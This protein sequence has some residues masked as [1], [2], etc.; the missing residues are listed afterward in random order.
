MNYVDIYEQ[1]FRNLLP[2]KNCQAHGIKLALNIVNNPFDF[3]HIP[4]SM[5]IH[6]KA[7]ERVRSCRKCPLKKNG[8][9]ISQLQ[10]CCGD[11][12][13]HTPKRPQQTIFC[14]LACAQLDKD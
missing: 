1:N 7:L 4:T 9:V 12:N 11:E 5:N 3:E 8:A 10:K 6:R 2:E 13:T 14:P